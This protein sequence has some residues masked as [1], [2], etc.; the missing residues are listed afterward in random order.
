MLVNSELNR[1][2]K[3]MLLAYVLL[4]FLGSLGIHRFYL[5]RKGSAI[6][7]LLLSVIGWITVFIIIGFIPLAIVY[8]WLFV[9]LFLI[10]GMVNRENE[11]I[12]K[13]IIQS[14]R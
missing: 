3:N 13:E 11:I 9:D 1:K 8:I 5:N 7:Q 2:G 12:E 6:A 14:L 4:I 10:P